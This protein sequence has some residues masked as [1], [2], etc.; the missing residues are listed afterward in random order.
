MIDGT[1]KITAIAAADE[2]WGIGRN[3]LLPWRCP[4]DLRHFKARTTG[5]TLLMG[6]TTF[7]GLPR[8]L[9]G[10]T[11]YVI[12]ATQEHPFNSP[13]CAIAS[14]KDRGLSE[15]IIAGGG[16]LYDTTLSF[17]THAEITRIAG[18]HDCDAFMPNLSERGWVMTSSVPLTPSINIEYW[19]KP[20][21][22]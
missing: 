8:K 4:E 15:I 16:R 22:H 14:L 19:E 7:D 13:E 1:T 11:I 12:S 18:T 5:H 2:V 10:R 9:E 21:G 6:R 3:G 20:S 17:C